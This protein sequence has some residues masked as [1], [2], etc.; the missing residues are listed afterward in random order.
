MPVSS[1]NLTIIKDLL[2][3]PDPDSALDATVASEWDHE[4]AVLARE[5]DLFTYSA[6][7]NTSIGQ[8]I[9]TLPVPTTRIY[10]LIFR[11]V[12]LGYTDAGTMNL[13]DADWELTLPD[14]PKFWSYNQIPPHADVPPAVVTYREFA[15]TPAPD[16]AQAG[17]GTLRLYAQEIPNS[18]YPSWVE[19]VLIYRTAGRVAAQNP[20]LMQP[21][22]GEFLNSLSDLWLEVVRKNLQV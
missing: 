2:L 6:V 17:P 14:K 20:N 12:T 7:L 18:G 5:Y 19:P 3:F 13:R 16:G 4:L 8:S 21:E 11:G 10:S 15:I 1:T 9:Y 22:K